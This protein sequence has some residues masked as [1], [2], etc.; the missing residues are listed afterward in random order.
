MYTIARVTECKL[1][2]NRVDTYVVTETE[3]LL[4]DSEIELPIEQL[5]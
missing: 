4:I 3:T 5:N 1:L 2:H